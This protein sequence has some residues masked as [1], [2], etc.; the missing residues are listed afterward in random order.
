MA[1]VIIG[2]LKMS[3]LTPYYA[4]LCPK[5]GETRNKSM[6]KIKKNTANR[7]CSICQKKVTPITIYIQHLE[8]FDLFFQL[9]K[10][11]SYEAGDTTV[12]YGE[13]LEDILK[14]MEKLK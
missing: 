10:K 5:C 12:S 9:M 4:W 13:V 2:K 8:N 14:E 1:I 7:Y 3:N 11:Y 6:V